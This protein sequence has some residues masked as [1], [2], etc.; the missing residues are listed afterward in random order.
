MAPP[1]S[2]SL[3]ASRS[4]GSSVDEDERLGALYDRLRERLLDLTNRNPMLNARVDPQRRSRR[5]LQIVDVALE[6][7]YQALRGDDPRVLDIAALADPGDV[8]PDEMTEAFVAAFEHAQL[9]D[10]DYLDA[11]ANPD[12]DG[13]DDAEP[14]AADE[15]L[16]LKVRADL[17]LPDRPRRHEIDRMQHAISLGLNPD[18]ELALRSAVPVGR[19]HLQTLRYADDLEDVLDRIADAARLSEQETGMS[20]LFLAIGFLE[21]PDPDTSG[22][23]FRAPLLLIPVRLVTRKADGRD[24]VGI[25]AEADADTNLSLRR[26]VEQ[27]FRRVLPDFDVGEDE[28][29][30]TIG[31]YLDCVS[32]AI[33]GLKDWHVR[34]WMVLGSFAFGRYQIYHDLQ[35]Q[36]WSQPP[37]AYPLVRAILSGT[38]RPGDPSDFAAA[39]EHDVDAPDVQQEVPHLIADADSSQHSAL[40]DVAR[41]ENLVIEGPPGTGKSQT[42]TN[43]IAHAIGQGKKVL[44]LSEKQAALDV[45]RRRLEQ[46]G[47]GPFCLDLHSDKAVPKTVV[48]ALR[49]RADLGWGKPRVSPRPVDPALIEAR[50]SIGRYLEG[51]HEPQADGETP[52]RLMWQSIRGARGQEA[53][54]EALRHLAPS[55]DWLDNPDQ[56]QAMNDVVEVY[57][58]AAGEF[59]AR[60]G[61]LGGS[62]WIRTGLHDIP[63]Y[64]LLRLR[65]AL[66]LWREPMLEVVSLM[67]GGADFGLVTL[68]D[69]GRLAEVDADLGDVAGGEFLTVFANADLRS[70]DEALAVHVKISELEARMAQTPDLVLSP[71]VATARAAELVASRF[72]AALADRI[73]LDLNRAI[74]A[75]VADAEELAAAIE[76]LMPAL[77]TLGLDRERS[78]EMFH[79]IALVCRALASMSAMRREQLLGFRQVAA[80]DLEGARKRHQDLIEAAADWRRHFPGLDPMH[81]PGVEEIR[82]AATWVRRGSLARA[83]GGMSPEAR[84]ARALVQAL[85]GGASAAIP[86]PVLLGQLADFVAYCEAFQADTILRRRFGRDWHGIATPFEAIEASIQLRRA[87]RQA[88]SHASGGAE[89]VDQLFSLADDGITMLIGQ[90]AAAERFLALAPDIRAR[91]KVFTLGSTIPQLEAEIRAA[92][93]LGDLAGD[94]MLMSL[95]RPLGVIADYH[96]ARESLGVLRRDLAG[97]PRA[98]EIADLI[99]DG[100][101]RE[102]IAAVNWIDDVR[103]RALPDDVKSAL[104][105]RHAVDVRALIGRIA[106]DA[107]VT[108]ARLREIAIETETAFGSFNLGEGDPSVLLARIDALIAQ[109]G[110]L[111][112]FLVLRRL[113]LDL[114]SDGLG[115]F[116]DTA[117]RLLVPMA[118][119]PQLFTTLAA[120]SRADH[121]RRSAGLAQATGLEMDVRRK[122]FAEHD[123]A[124]IATDRV[125]IRTRLTELSALKPIPGNNIGPKSTWTELALLNSEFVKSSRYLPIRGLLARAGRSIQALTPC[126]MMSPLSLAK[127]TSP[128]KLEFDLVVIDEASQMR[129]EDALGA[130]LRAKQLVVVGDP[131]QLP[132]NDFFRRGETGSMGEAAADDDIEAESIL[133]ICARSFGPCGG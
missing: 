130:L 80:G 124:R 50:Q 90:A 77:S 110:Q 125:E 113:K 133:E 31:G 22:K 25:V 95:E 56:L 65:A 39:P 79:D 111:A 104:T 102:A 45:V 123:R 10:S 93:A 75:R 98:D 42:I 119:L 28:S 44:F 83:L 81:L 5:M 46:A 1:S 120:Q 84:T 85:M 20:T 117:E 68:A 30:G 59:E 3:I 108:L 105:G 129:P 12:S 49:A 78:G 11:I 101:P 36:N 14:G 16:R 118:T 131:K 112:D 67:R 51:L 99:G 76:R 82:A 32:K 24:V 47:L 19:L 72:G 92:A 94:P 4:V 52:F 29:I 2:I 23:T 55:G 96:T 8:P 60:H 54:F 26:L 115:T 103:T 97:L 132:P 15:A 61:S 53:I 27:D 40:V 106:R 91:L 13:R 35:A 7:V 6:A 109:H 41:Q 73:P 88:M 121:A 122:I 17:G 71:R 69:L 21:R 58:L 87:F 74:R 48:E 114:A 116:L 33:D 128:G 43:I 107:R 62:P 66:T 9:T 63:A 57:A 18:P 89:V 127:F 70:V 37:I 64:D 100:D 86:D 126:F 34:P 38:D